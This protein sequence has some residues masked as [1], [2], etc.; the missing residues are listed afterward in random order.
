MSVSV[1]VRD[2][3]CLCGC[4]YMV[5]CECVYDNVSVSHVSV[6]ICVRVCECVNVSE[7]VCGVFICVL[8]MIY[9]C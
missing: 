6:S 7:D 4:V 3:M 9:V 5:V 2:W 8:Y 1:S